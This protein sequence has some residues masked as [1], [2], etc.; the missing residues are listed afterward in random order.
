LV[1]SGIAEIDAAGRRRQQA[2]S[3]LA[4]SLNTELESL[5]VNPLHADGA[6]IEALDALLKWQLPS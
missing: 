3:A 1:T 4:Q 6:Q 2:L 5:Q